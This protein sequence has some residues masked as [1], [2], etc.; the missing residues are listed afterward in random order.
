[1]SRYFATELSDALFAVTPHTAALIL[2]VVP[3]DELLKKVQ[4]SPDA[5]VKETVA[6]DVANLVRAS[7]IIRNGLVVP[8]TPVRPSVTSGESLEQWITATEAAELLGVTP[9]TVGNYRGAGTIKFKQKD[10]KSYLY[11]KKSVEALAAVARP[12][13]A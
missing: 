11:D 6:R 7:R 1:M 3:A 9:R 5:K 13:A 8:D 12:K 2:A 4:F 10:G